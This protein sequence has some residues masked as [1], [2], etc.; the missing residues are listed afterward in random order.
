MMVAVGES[1]L[2]TS[3]SKKRGR[4]ESSHQDD[5]HLR[6]DT[7]SEQH[8]TLGDLPDDIIGCIFKHAPQIG[9]VLHTLQLLQ[10]LEY[11]YGFFFPR[12]DVVISYRG[13][14]PHVRPCYE[15]EIAN[16]ITRL[17]TTET[18]KD[19]GTVT[20]VTA[21]GMCENP[22]SFFRNILNPDN[23]SH[24]YTCGKFQEQD[25]EEYKVPTGR[26]KRTIKKVPTCSQACDS[27]LKTML[28]ICK[29]Q[30]FYDG[31]YE[32]CDGD[33]VFCV[34]CVC[35]LPSSFMGEL[36]ICVR[37]VNMM[38]PRQKMCKWVPLCK[39]SEYNHPPFD[40]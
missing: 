5:K 10:N 18:T 27:I 40:I 3:S 7:H 21:A 23:P 14:K 1:L 24:C 20:S 19:D 22:S 35:K 11:P 29:F 28:N 26:K 32:Y 6:F 13:D 37:G 8:L 31:I 34:W 30:S 12:A 33:D 15:G 9:C 16:T 36:H 25:Y 17:V 4:D 38:N 39:L 2:T